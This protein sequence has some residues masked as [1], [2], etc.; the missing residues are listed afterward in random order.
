MDEDDKPA[1]GPICEE[2]G[3]SRKNLIKILMKKERK[4]KFEMV[5]IF[6]C[7]YHFLQKLE[8][9][10]EEPP[11]KEEDVPEDDLDAFKEWKEHNPDDDDDEGWS[12]VSD[13]EGQS[14]G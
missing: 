1:I 6:L 2:C 10:A 13:C 5:P 4:G 8:N 9:D 7:L 3:C 12:C 14:F 11:K